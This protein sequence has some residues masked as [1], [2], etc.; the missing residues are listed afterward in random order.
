MKESLIPSSV[1]TE[2]HRDLV[3]AARLA[4]Q[5]LSKPARARSVLI[6]ALVACSALVS[7]INATGGMVRDREE[8]WR[9]VPSAD[10][11][12][13]DLGDAAYTAAGALHEA[14]LEE[15]LGEDQG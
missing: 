5:L 15:N 7:T 4:D 12:W 6:D 1:A 11:E 9:M 2:L 14:G 3:A 8:D 10:P 13:V